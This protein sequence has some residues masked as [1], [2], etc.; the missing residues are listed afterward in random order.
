MLRLND[1]H[2]PTSCGAERWR[3]KVNTGF[4]VA[5]MFVYISRLRHVTQI[6]ET[7]VNVLFKRLRHKMQNSFF[8]R[9]CGSG[10]KRV[11]SDPAL[12]EDKRRYLKHPQF[13]IRLNSTS[14]FQLRVLRGSR[15]DRQSVCS[16]AGMRRGP[17][18]N[19][20]LF[21]DSVSGDR[22]QASDPDVHHQ[23]LVSRSHVP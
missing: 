22:F 11:T 15:P 1:Q 20:E 4:V 14:N 5:F 21:V 8:W 10:V 19:A 7:A 13:Q 3:M 6:L 17:L 23:Q 9:P 12:A 2:I 16:R 18:T